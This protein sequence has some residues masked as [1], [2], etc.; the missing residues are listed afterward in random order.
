[1]LHSLIRKEGCRTMYEVYCDSFLLYSSTID[2]L[3]IIK[4]KVSL[5]DN[6]TGSFTFTIYPDHP[7]YD[8]IKK[9][10]SLVTVYQDDYLLFRGRVLNEEIGFY[11]EKS[12]TC[13]GE[14]AFLLDSIQRPYNYKGSITGFLSQLITAHNSQVDKS[15][16]FALGN[17]TVTDPNNTITRSDIN[18]SKTWEVIDKKLIAL[19]GGHIIAR[20]QNGVNY[21]DYL[22]D[23]TAIS[24][25]KIEFAKNLLDMERKRKGQDII[26]ALIPLGANLKD[27]EGNETKERLTIKSENGGLD[28]ITD[29]DAVAQYGLIFETNIWDDV[30]VA[31]NLLTKG[32]AYLASLS[33]AIDTLELSAADLA[34]IEENINSFHLG[35][36]VRVTSNPHGIDQ[37]FRVTKLQIDLMNPAANK[38]TLGGTTKTLTGNM[39][40]V[41]DVKNGKDGKDGKDAAIQSD[42]PPTDTSMLWLDTSLNPP[43]LKRYAPEYQL[44]VAEPSDWASNYTAYFTFDSNTGAYSA[45]TGTTTPAWAEG[46]YYQHVEWVT[47]NDTTQ[48]FYLM[49]K[50]V[51]SEISKSET[52]IMSK[53]SE[54]YYLKDETDSLISSVSTTVEQNK[55]SVDILFNQYSADLEALANGTDANFEEI[56][57]YIRFVE[58]KILLGEVGNELELQIANNRI[59]F[60]Q[61]NAEVAYFSNNKLY[62][63]D[64]EYTNSLRLGQFAFLP[65][66][67][68]NLSF[69]KIT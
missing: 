24:N 7:Y 15:K 29:A 35:T 56:R 6:K 19:L 37:N 57:K 33:S 47:V 63:T 69:K 60:L 42:T 31:S 65:R 17:V 48:A 36:Y 26:T 4:P 64:G 8:V 38:L 16:Q 62:V 27:A 41:L 53:V 67:N 43:L 23:Y 1:M 32:R 45:I 18:Y 9:L 34:G 44:L 66:E 54:E 12:I 25:Q 20:H 58:G 5:E 59:S 2:N 50:N 51:S 21:I 52:N 11:N 39:T 68:G 3:K 22:A 10:T 61:S 46:T 40:Q 14:L 13:E 28:Y 30:T 55:N 49:E